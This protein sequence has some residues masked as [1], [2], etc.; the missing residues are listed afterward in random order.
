MFRA[1]VLA[2]TILALGTSTMAQE[3]SVAQSG[4]RTP[5]N[6]FG[7]ELLGRPLIYSFNYERLLWPR[8]GIGGGFAWWDVDVNDTFHHTRTKAVIVPLYASWTPIG[9]RHS[10]YLSAGATLGLSH[11]REE[12]GSARSRGRAGAM[13]TGTIGYQYRSRGGFMIRPTVNL[14]YFSQGALLWPG[15]TIGYDF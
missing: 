2:A 8:I 6:M 4:P 13:G 9:V 11:V 5:P 3:S 7:F 1:I 12:S 14:L 15:L 10:L